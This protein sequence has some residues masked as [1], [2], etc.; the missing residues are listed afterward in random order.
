MDRVLGLGSTQ[1]E[2]PP[3]D[4]VLHRIAGTESLADL[5][6]RAGALRDAGHGANVSYSRKVFIPLTRLCRDVCGYCTFAETPR[7][8][9]AAYLSADEVLAIARADA[10]VWLPFLTLQSAPFPKEKAWP[11]LKG[12]CSILV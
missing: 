11:N 4:D 7:R 8:G 12:F 3:P 5:M 2:A 10:R 9:I 6:A 1:R